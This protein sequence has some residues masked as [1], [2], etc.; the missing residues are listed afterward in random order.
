MNFGLHC[1]LVGGEPQGQR[2][3]DHRNGANA[4]T[5]RPEVSQRHQQSSGGEWQRVPRQRPPA[6]GI[7]IRCSS[8][9]GFGCG[10]GLGYGHVCGYGHGSWFPRSPAFWERMDAPASQRPSVAPSA[11]SFVGGLGGLDHADGAPVA[12]LRAGRTD[13]IVPPGGAPHDVFRSAGGRRMGH[14]RKTSRTARPREAPIPRTRCGFGCGFGHGFG[15]GHGFGHGLGY[16][17]G[18]GCG[19][20]YGHGRG[21]LVESSP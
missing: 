12:C 7:G 4:K 8:G 18:F 20:G 5:R 3:S 17:Y 15:Y 10:H 11:W 13:F 19:L 2:P 9:H 1:S 21:Q 14:E 16:G 6:I